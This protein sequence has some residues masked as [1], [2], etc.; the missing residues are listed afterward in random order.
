MLTI[1]FIRHGE[2]TDN[3]RAV[4]AG[5]SDSPLSNH[6][7]NQA[8]A[9]GAHLSNTKFTAIYSSDLKRAHMTALAIYEAQPEP[10]P[11]LYATKDL[12]EQHFGIAEGEPWVIQSDEG[13][14]IEKKI[15]PVPFGRVEK[16]PEGE[17]LD[18]LAVRATRVINELILP[19]IWDAEKTYGKREGEVH[20]AV[21]SHGLCIYETM[22]ALVKLDADGYGDQAHTFKGLANTGWFR[23]TLAVKDEDKNPRPASINKDTP[24]TVRVTHLNQKDH[25]HDVIRHE[26]GIEAHD[27]K[28]KEAK[29]FFAGKISV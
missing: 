29:E 5:W 7:M 26:G 10:K 11:A 16:F 15:F 8:R 25:L 9:C 23:A 14:N 2:S 24:L 12:R 17:S 19:W 20:I 21:V 28:Q 27:S 18:D 22:R 1:T 4:W 6:G 3:L 13:L